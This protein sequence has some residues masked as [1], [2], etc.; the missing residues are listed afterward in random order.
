MEKLKA[1]LM[2]VCQIGFFVASLVQ[3]AAVYSFFNDYWG[4]WFVF[5]LPAAL[6]AGGIPLVGAIAGTYA[7]H[8]VWGWDLFNAI[9]LFF[10][11]FILILPLMV[12]GGAESFFAKFKKKT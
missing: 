1:A 5:A 4:W 7:A 9:L 2:L 8:E 11:Y 12:L 6:I 10:W 3:V